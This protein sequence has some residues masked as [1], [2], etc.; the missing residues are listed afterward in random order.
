VLKVLQKLP[1]GLAISVLA[2]S[3]AGL[4]KQLSF[5]SKSLHPLAIEA[6]FPSI[7][8]H[9]SLTLNV[10]FL[11]TPTTACAVL[12]AATIA[13]IPLQK[14]H[15]WLIPV[16]DNEHLLQLI[17]AA[18]RSALHVCFHFTHSNPHQVP[19]SQP[20]EQL[21]ATL[22]QNTALTSLQLTFPDIPYH[23][24][25]FN[26]LLE[27]L[28]SLRTLKLAPRGD[29]FCELPPSYHLPPVR[30]SSACPS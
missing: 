17:S 7:R 14:L 2:A 23:F 1:E 4:E 19:D 25:T 27:S 12:H 30:H 21:E 24:F 28:K 13:T 15:L 3:G 6:A 29:L 26:C 9:H 11:G 20:F 16:C 18:C 10:A 5:L 8:R 22:S